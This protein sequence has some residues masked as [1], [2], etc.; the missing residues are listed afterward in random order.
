MVAP[1]VGV[2]AEGAQDASGLDSLK[3]QWQVVSK[4]GDDILKKISL[5]QGGEGVLEKMSDMN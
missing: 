3:E 1:L 4:V 5:G 2:R